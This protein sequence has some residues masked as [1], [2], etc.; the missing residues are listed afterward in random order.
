M[1][2]RVG[3]LS[4]GLILMELWRLLGR[5][6]GAGPES[7]LAAARVGVAVD[8]RSTA[9]V[10]T[11]TLGVSDDHLAA[12]VLRLGGRSR[13]SGWR[14][15]FLDGERSRWAWRGSHVRNLDLLLAVLAED[16]G[17]DFSVLQ[18]LFVDLLDQLSGQ[19]VDLHSAS[20]AD[21]TLSATGI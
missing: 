6:S 13:R 18:D 10:V 7:A 2:F 20:P 5:R 1:A 17:A 14:R 21:D 8:H 15:D 11:A 9:A 19:G 3:L 16:L 4:R 12:V